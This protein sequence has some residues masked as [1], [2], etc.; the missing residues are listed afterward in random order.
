MS[1]MSAA[2][3]RLME[4]WAHG[5]DIADTVGVPIIPSRRLRHVAYLG[6]ATR[7][8][9]FINHGL[10]APISEAR[11]EL[12]SGVGEVWSFGPPDATDRVT[13]SALAFCLVVTQ[14]RTLDQ[15]E[16]RL[17]GPSSH[18]WMSVAQAFAGPPTTAAPRCRRD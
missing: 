7:R 12:D 3:A 6:F 13:G 17:I 1:V 4:T 11:V 16:L 2:T 10:E 5:V 8:F 15:T 14:R 9:S 18:D